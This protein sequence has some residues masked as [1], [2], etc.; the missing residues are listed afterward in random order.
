MERFKWQA[1]QSQVNSWHT[2]T[3]LIC[4]LPYQHKKYEMKFRMK[5]AKARAGVF[6]LFY[7]MRVDDDTKMETLLISF[8]SFCCWPLRRRRRCWDPPRSAACRRF[9]GQRR[10]SSPPLPLVSFWQS[11]FPPRVFCATLSVGFETIPA[12]NK[13]CSCLDIIQW[14][15]GIYIGLAGGWELINVTS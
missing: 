14:S 10:R 15:K 3:K 1:I 12:H 2:H 13:N 8:V 7:T 6:T 11:P 4:C 5:K 9:P